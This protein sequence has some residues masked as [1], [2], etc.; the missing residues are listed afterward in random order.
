MNEVQ[1][2]DATWFLS[3]FA[4]AVSV[5][6]W[7]ITGY[8]ARST[9]HRADQTAN[10]K[11]ASGRMDVAEN[12]IFDILR[13]A[14]SHRPSSEDESQIQSRLTVL[15][16]D[17]RRLDTILRNVFD[18]ELPGEVRRASQAYHRLARSVVG[19]QK[20]GAA[21]L[22]PSDAQQVDLSNQAGELVNIMRDTWK[23]KEN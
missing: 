20:S 14:T 12:L 21:P 7:I 5:V 16:N 18:Q 2:Y 6:G 23:Q 11:W 19:S 9:A 10:R 17:F 4:I 13:E 8:Y 3:F 1:N 22:S 15:E